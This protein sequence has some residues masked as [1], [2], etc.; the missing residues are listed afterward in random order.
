MPMECSPEHL[1][2]SY[3]SAMSP[4]WEDLEQDKLWLGQPISSL[5][6][7]HIVNLQGWLLR[8]ASKFK[9]LC[10]RDMYR[11]S[12]TLGGEMAIDAMDTE[13]AQL[14]EQNPYLWMEER[15]LFK[16][17]KRSIEERQGYHYVRVL[18]QEASTD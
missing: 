4:E 7:G 6:D 14:E 1:A 8:N 2:Q 3:V 12:S 9:S 17:I 15:P 11:F 13:I 18:P 5:T 16:A 10:L